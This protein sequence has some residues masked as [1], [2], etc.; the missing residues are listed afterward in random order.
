MLKIGPT[1]RPKLLVMAQIHTIQTRSRALNIS[2]I[3]PITTVVGIADK[4]PLTKRPT[5]A[6]ESDGTAATTRQLMLYRAVLM[7]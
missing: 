2:S 3:L 4:N 6:P 1:I 7:M 5:V